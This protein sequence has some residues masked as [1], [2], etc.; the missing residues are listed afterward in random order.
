MFKMFFAW[1]DAYFDNRRLTQAA[2]YWARQG[3][4]TPYAE[5]ELERFYRL[6][7]EECRAYVCKRYLEDPTQ[8][9]D[10]LKSEWIEANIT[11]MLKSSFCKQDGKTLLAAITGMGEE[12]F[13]GRAAVRRRL[14]INHAVAD[15]RYAS[16]PIKMAQRHQALRI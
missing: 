2:H 14:E 5:A 15:A 8:I 16:G 3:S 13:F 12:I 10:D 11:P 4:V 9:L 1:L 7:L 6:K